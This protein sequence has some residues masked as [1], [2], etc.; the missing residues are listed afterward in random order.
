MFLCPDRGVLCWV[1]CTNTTSTTYVHA[2][3]PEITRCDGDGGFAGEGGKW[4]RR[5]V[6]GRK[7]GVILLGENWDGK[8]KPNDAFTDFF[9][10]VFRP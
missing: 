7:G 5:R 2:T 3:Y 9:A 4:G 8:I 6:G 10:S 1:H